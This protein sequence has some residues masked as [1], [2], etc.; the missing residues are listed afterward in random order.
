[1]NT[2]FA[3]HYWPNQDAL[4]KRFHLRSAQGPLVQI[5]DIAK[6]AKY[7]WIAEP[8]LGFIYLPYTQENG[9]P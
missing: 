8:P 4:G 9:L 7:F 6:T 1:V 3:N 2:Q 5:V